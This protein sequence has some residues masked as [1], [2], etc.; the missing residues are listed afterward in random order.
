MSGLC[1]AIAAARGGAQVLLMQD[2]PVL[3]GNASSE[4]RMQISGALG[5]NNLETGILEEIK[6]ENAHR[7]PGRNYSI[8]DS[9]T[10]EAAKLQSGLTL[11]LNCSCADLRMDDDRI[12]SIRGWQLTTYTW[13]E[14]HAGLFVDAS[15]DSILAPLSGA[16]HTSGREGRGEYGEDIG[17]EVFDTKTM[18]MSC[19][20]QARE[21]L[22]T[23]TYRPPSWANRYPDKDA[24]G[25]RV[26]DPN[27]KVNNW[28]WIELGGEQD[29][30]HDTENIRDELVKVAFGV[31]DHVKNYGHYDTDNW[32]LD[33]VGF[34]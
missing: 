19:L 4:I 15:G 21:T 27:D 6:L 16:E 10:Y 33:W 24:F 12:V 14:V 30:I 34:G 18:G 7:N 25:S 5:R 20:I 31:W 32:S 2:R 22:G 26:V 17:P 13:H 1:A 3:G 23:V 29:S 28:W 9:V 8:W 11:L